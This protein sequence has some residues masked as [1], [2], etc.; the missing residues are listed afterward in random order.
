MKSSERNTEKNS[1]ET[2]VEVIVNDTDQKDRLHFFEQVALPT[3]QRVL[4]GYN[5]ALLVVGATGTGKTLL[6][7]GDITSN[8]FKI[9]KGKSGL[10]IVAIDRV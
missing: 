3:I 6:T 5:G 9:D 10:I 2:Q 4:D 1:V 7:T 8:K